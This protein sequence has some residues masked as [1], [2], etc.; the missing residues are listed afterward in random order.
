MLIYLS[1]CIEDFDP[2]GGHKQIDLSSGRRLPV[3]A[4]SSRRET[5]RREMNK[6]SNRLMTSRAKQ[7]R[8]ELTV[9]KR[10]QIYQQQIT[11]MKA[12]HQ[13]IIQSAR[14]N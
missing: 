2:L 13:Y 11:L 14:E 3:G 1:V 10:Q 4:L 7:S 8:A 5:T 12:K 9:V 6:G